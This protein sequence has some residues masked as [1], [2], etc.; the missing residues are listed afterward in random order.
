MRHPD[1]SRNELH[2]KGRRHVEGYRERSNQAYPTERKPSDMPNNGRSTSK[3]YR[4]SVNDTEAQYF[5]AAERRTDRTHSTRLGSFQKREDV[6]N[7][8]STRRRIPAVLEDTAYSKNPL[9]NI[10]KPAINVYYPLS[11]PSTDQTTPRNNVRSYTSTSTSSG[12]VYSNEEYSL[13]VLESGTSD[14]FTEGGRG[15]YLED[16]S[17]TTTTTTNNSTDDGTR[18]SRARSS[19]RQRDRMPILSKSV[20]TV[21]TSLETTATVGGVGD[22]SGGFFAFIAS[23]LSGVLTTRQDFAY[24]SVIFISLQ[25]LILMLQLTMCGIAPFETNVMIGPYPDAFSVWGGKNPYLLLH[26]EWWRLLTPTILNVG[27]LHLAINAGCIFSACALFEREWGGSVWLFFL[28]VGTIG[29]T[30][31]S[32]YADP[33]TI[34][35]GSSGAM[36]GL[37]GAKLSELSMQVLGSSS[38][39]DDRELISLRHVSVILLGMILNFFTGCFTYIDLSGNLGGLCSGLAAG[40]FYF[41]YELR[42]CCFRLLAVLFGVCSLIVPSG[43]ALHFFL[44]DAEP[45]EQLANVCQYFRS[46]FPE[47]YECGC[48]W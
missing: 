34:A 1:Q 5:Y 43:A 38:K 7:T 17:T 35:V 14:S 28:F 33:D 41:S 46:M 19:A 20:S 10:K 30:A 45:D 9:G 37:Y 11:D 47:D 32:N 23:D 36:M 22:D 48:M 2:N 26:N 4:P 16:G 29:C 39:H 21:S 24:C 15:S 27:I 13:G 25:L 12:E 3:R 31:F 18:Q 44:L 40:S 42:S 6:S 8:S